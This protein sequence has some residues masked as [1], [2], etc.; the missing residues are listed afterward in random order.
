MT[1]AAPAT[2]SQAT[3]QF[4]S[5]RDARI[6][7]PGGKYQTQGFASEPATRPSY[8]PRTT[9]VGGT[10]YDIIFVPGMGYGYYDPYGAYVPYVY[11][12]PFYH[13]VGLDIFL[14]ILLIVVI[15]VIAAA[16]SKR[17][18]GY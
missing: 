17:S 1:G 7:G 12:P 3:S 6:A 10:H 15:A 2:R 13:N 4:K 18:S 11:H 9:Y 16:V 5:D 14:I 8:V